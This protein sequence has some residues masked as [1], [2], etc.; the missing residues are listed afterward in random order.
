MRRGVTLIEL[1]VALT[2]ATL[3]FGAV[4]I[5][6]GSLTGAS[7]KRATTELAGTIRA[8]YDTAAVSGRTC[9]LV[10]AM[11][12]ERDVPSKHSWRAEC[13]KGDVAV[14]RE[15]PK[16]KER[17]PR[18]SPRSD[19]PYAPTLQELTLRE[20]ERV[21]KAVAFSNFSDEGLEPHELPAG[22][23]LE[24]WTPKQARPV[25]T[26]T[27]YLYFFAQG[28]SERARIWLQQGSNAWTVSVAPLTG[29]T[30]IAADKLEVPAT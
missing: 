4:T 9:R 27:A 21:D 17:P 3:L 13:A 7:A 20:E 11:P 14:Q 8:M 16:Q 12:T 28:Y 29:K 6:I 1:I 26:G 18:S 24:V 2:I 5:G 23:H 15:D 19:S 10:F 25:T 22:V 30:S